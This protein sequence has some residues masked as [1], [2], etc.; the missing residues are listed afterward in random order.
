MLT[1]MAKRGEYRAQ[2]KEDDLS[3]ILDS[4]Q[5][6][7]I[8]KIAVRDSILQKPGKLTPE[9]FEEVKT[10]SRAGAEIIDKI[11]K[12]VAESSFLDYARIFAV[13]HHEKW[14]GTGYP[15]G[16]A[17]EDIPLLG[18]LMAFADVYDALVSDRPYKK[19]FSHEDAVAIIQDGK[20]KHFDPNLVD[21][22]VEVADEFKKV[23]D[24][25]A[26]GQV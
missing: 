9:E 1:A 13:S 6:H 22:F 11:K 5:L 8:G 16:L 17:G 14:D 23:C 18:R 26:P 24:Q 10:H 21:I 12:N 4:A 7:D 2:I 20:G 15:D 3:I 19:P 25:F